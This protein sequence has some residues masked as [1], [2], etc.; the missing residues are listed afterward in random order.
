ML[1]FKS[2]AVNDPSY[3]YGDTQ[4]LKIYK[5]ATNESVFQ[6]DQWVFSTQVYTDTKNIIWLY[7]VK[8]SSYSG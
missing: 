6:D 1:G 7:Y 2:T 4:M 8:I 5:L 3:N